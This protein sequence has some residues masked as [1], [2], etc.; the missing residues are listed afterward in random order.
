MAACWQVVGCLMSQNGYSALIYAADKGHLPVAELLLKSGAKV[1]LDTLV[2]TASMQHA[3]G[4]CAH[5]GTAP[6]PRNAVPS[7]AAHARS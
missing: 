4:E 5:L 1:D 3:C 6:R 2:R 7:P